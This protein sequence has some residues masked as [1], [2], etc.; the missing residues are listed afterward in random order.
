MPY[1]RQDDIIA[2]TLEQGINHGQDENIRPRPCPSPLPPKRC[3][4]TR[5]L[6]RAFALPVWF[7]R[8]KELSKRIATA[9][10]APIVV[11]DV[12]QDEAA[13]E[14]QLRYM[15]SLDGVPLD[16]AART[17]EK[18]RTLSELLAPFSC[19]E[20]EETV[21]HLT[22]EVTKH[23]L[24][25]LWFVFA[26]GGWGRTAGKRSEPDRC[27]VLCLGVERVT[28]S[29]GWFFRFVG[30]YHLCCGWWRGCLRWCTNRDDACE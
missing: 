15:A 16:K 3:H 27:F 6:V 8:E 28:M 29:S 12:F 30:R 19:P 11:G 10:R 21:S 26:F 1:V 9:A 7:C 25:F 22:I 13:G 5:C 17:H 2:R 14:L 24:R 20:T 23:F 4:G 18:L